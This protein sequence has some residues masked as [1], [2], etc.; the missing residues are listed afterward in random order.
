MNNMKKYTWDDLYKRADGAACGEP[1]LKTKDEAREQVRCFVLDL[2]SIDI[3]NEECPEDTV[4]YYCNK[5]SIRFDEKGNIIEVRDKSNNIII[6]YGT[7]I[8]VIYGEYTG[9]T[10]FIM[11]DILKKCDKK[12]VSTEITGFYFGKPNI[13]DI[14]KYNGKLKQNFK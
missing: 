3:E 7:N 10:T 1:T 4:E 11:K 9:M 12:R 14:E 13:E 6:Q 5:Y 8:S 2:D